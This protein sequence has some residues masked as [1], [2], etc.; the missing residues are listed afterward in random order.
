MAAFTFGATVDTCWATAYTLVVG[1]ADT[2]RATAYTPVVGAAGTLLA[3]EVA[4]VSLT[5]LRGILE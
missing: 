1:A 5:E 3:Y 4:T 2:L